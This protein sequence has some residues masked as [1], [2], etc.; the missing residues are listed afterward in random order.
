MCATSNDDSG[1]LGV[2]SGRELGLFS[3]RP[4]VDSGVELSCESG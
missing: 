1:S 3:T 4:G 2:V